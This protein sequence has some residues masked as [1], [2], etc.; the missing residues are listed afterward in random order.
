M[1]HPVTLPSIRRPR[2]VASSTTIDWTLC[3]RARWHARICIEA[4]IIDVL[5]TW[6][7]SNLLQ[8]TLAVPIHRIAW[9]WRRL[10]VITRS[11]HLISRES[12]SRRAKTA[13]P[14]WSTLG[15]VVNIVERRHSCNHAVAIGISNI[16]LWQARVGM[17]V[18]F[19]W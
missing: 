3:L 1:W 9:K 4:S 2:E 18:T 14:V 12:R 5:V 8:R 11:G 17:T 16:L 7:P 19:S 15:D 6:W 13:R 10:H